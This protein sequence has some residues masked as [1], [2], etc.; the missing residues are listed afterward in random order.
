MNSMTQEQLRAVLEVLPMDM[1][2]V[3]E[4]D[5]VRFWNRGAERGPA[6][7]PSR[8]DSPVQGCHLA[9]SVAALD[10]ILSDFRNG[11]RDVVEERGSA[12]GQA[13]RVRW[14][15]VRDESGRY[16]GTLEVVQRGTEAPG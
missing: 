13:K 14:F 2:F 12:D 9:K 11:V 16:L 7:Q 4:K 10:A 8:L 1:A 15:A 6:W 5:N 3:D